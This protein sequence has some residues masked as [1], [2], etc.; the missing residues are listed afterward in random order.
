MEQVISGAV[1][2]EKVTYNEI[3]TNPMI[4]WINLLKKYES[5][6]RQSLEKT[7]LEFPLFRDIEYWMTE[8]DST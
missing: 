4:I 8:I 1:W 6:Y 5:Q 7:C 3:T 2:L